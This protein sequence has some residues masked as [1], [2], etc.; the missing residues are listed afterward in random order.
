MLFERHRLRLC[1]RSNLIGKPYRLSIFIF[2]AFLL[3]LIY[4]GNTSLVLT[5]LLDRLAA[6][7]KFVH[8]SVFDFFFCVSPEAPSLCLHTVC[9]T[10]WHHLNMV[11]VRQGIATLPVDH[12]EQ[13]TDV[14]S[15][16]IVK[17]RL[18]YVAVVPIVCFV[19]LRWYNLWQVKSESLNHPFFE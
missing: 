15:P 4:R 3:V 13:L 9:S 7:C 17:Q 19:C 1:T 2:Y 8:F 18:L 11:T 12:S 5:Y 14:I 6:K 10:V 16:C